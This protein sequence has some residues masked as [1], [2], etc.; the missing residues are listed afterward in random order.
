MDEFLTGISWECNVYVGRTALCQNGC[1]Y[2]RR[3]QTS[4]KNSSLN[5]NLSKPHLHCCQNRK[6]RTNSEFGWISHTWL[7]LV[8]LKRF[9]FG[10]ESNNNYSLEIYRFLQANC[11]EYQ[12]T[13]NLTQVGVLK[14]KRIDIWRHC[15]FRSTSV[16]Q[17][18]ECS[19][20][21]LLMFT[22]P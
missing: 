21:F 8:N 14:M 18:S 22:F 12:R 6:R 2:T 5:S 13:I 15:S 16:Q 9:F 4:R 20:A 3:N 11:Q 1:W 10:S 7:F 19:A 17:G